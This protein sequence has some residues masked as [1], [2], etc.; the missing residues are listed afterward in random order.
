M[1]LIAV[2]PPELSVHRLALE[3]SIS[4]SLSNPE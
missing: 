1:F 2:L 4:N 3:R